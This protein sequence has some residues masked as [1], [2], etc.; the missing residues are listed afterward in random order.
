MKV[1]LDDIENKINDGGYDLSDKQ[2]DWLVA[3]LKWTR[4][5]AEKWDALK[6]Q[7]SSDGSKGQLDAWATLQVQIQKQERALRATL[8][9]FKGGPWTADMS[10]EWEE[11]TGEDEAC[12]KNLCNFIRKV[13]NE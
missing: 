9:F 13:L 11:L 1:K 2:I 6:A 8:L 5:R 3:E 10:Q 7:K 12:S 4:E